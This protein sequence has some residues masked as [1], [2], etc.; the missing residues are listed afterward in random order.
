MEY[1]E[2]KMNK[3]VLNILICWKWVATNQKQVYCYFDA[4]FACS[5][6]EEKNIYL[7]C[8]K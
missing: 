2:N 3:L 8:P 4:P 7:Q 1:L 6:F 5:V